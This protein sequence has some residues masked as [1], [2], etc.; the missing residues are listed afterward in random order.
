MAYLTL[1]S[2]IRTR[3]G[4]GKPESLALAFAC[5]GYDLEKLKSGDRNNAKLNEDDQIEKIRELVEKRA[6]LNAIGP[7]GNTPLILAVMYSIA[8]EKT[9]SEKTASE[10]TIRFLI[11]LGADTSHKNEWGLDAASVALRTDKPD[12][13]RVIKE[14]CAEVKLR[15]N[16]GTSPESSSKPKV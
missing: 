1:N 6:D 8:S 4:Y 16:N 9:A 11:G 2:N 15:K 12:I 7:V 10:K 3:P 13:F 5:A 14:A